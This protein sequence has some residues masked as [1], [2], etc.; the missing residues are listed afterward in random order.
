MVFVLASA[1]TYALWGDLK[2]VAIIGLICLC[3]IPILLKAKTLFSGSPSQ[4]S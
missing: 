3:A 2:S 4:P 1:I